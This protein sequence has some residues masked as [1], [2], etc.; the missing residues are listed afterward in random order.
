[1]APTCQSTSIV[2]GAAAETGKYPKPSRVRLRQ[3]TQLPAVVSSGCPQRE[4]ST[5]CSPPMPSTK[6][7]A[8]RKGSTVLRS[9]STTQR[10][11]P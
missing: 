2:Y 9:V 6:K 4:N 8:T 5:S 10:Y 1:V 7:A 3:V 11:V